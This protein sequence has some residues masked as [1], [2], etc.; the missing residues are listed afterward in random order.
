MMSTIDR[1]LISTFFS[2]SGKLS[3]SFTRSDKTSIHCCPITGNVYSFIASLPAFPIFS[4]SLLRGHE[5]KVRP[6]AS[7]YV[8][9]ISCCLFGL[10]H[11]SAG[12]H[13]VI[14][15]AI[16]GIL[17]MIALIYTG[18]LWP[19]IVAHFVTDVVAF[20]GLIPEGI[21]ELFK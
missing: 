11:W 15:T 18:S 2:G 14:A 7:C 8:I 20:S 12:L 19:A 9:A 5:G 1:F 21:Y 16:W 10:I 6:T 4:R 13:A 3:F 17:P